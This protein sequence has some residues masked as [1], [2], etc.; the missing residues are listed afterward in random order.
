[1]KHLFVALTALVFMA[2]TTV[3]ADTEKTKEPVDLANEFLE[4]VADGSV[5]EAVQKGFSTELHAIMGGSIVP[6]VAQINAYIPSLTG[7]ILESEL[8][9][10]E[11]I[12][13]RF[14]R[15]V[16]LTYTERLAV[17]WEF[18]YYQV[19]GSWSLTS[20]R[21]HTEPFQILHFN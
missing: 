21:F 18:F 5:N 17:T 19:N 6:L 12:S 2:A 1:M 15:L 8:I 14:R 10:D 13:K 7:E 4:R 20:F 11:A 9:R 16:F 3:E